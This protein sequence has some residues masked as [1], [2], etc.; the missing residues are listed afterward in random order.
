[1]QNSQQMGV[2]HS[3]AQQGASQAAPVQRQGQQ[4]EKP[5]Q[6]QGSATITDW[7]SI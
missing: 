6:Q 5:V 3:T 1:M 7:A 2:S 4:S